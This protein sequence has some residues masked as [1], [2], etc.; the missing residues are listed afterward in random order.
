MKTIGVWRLALVY[1]G[2]FLGA[3]YFSGQELWLFF[4]HFGMGG[5]WGVLLSALLQ[6]VLCV[7]LLSLARRGEIERVEHAVIQREWRGLRTAVG[8]AEIFLLL[9]VSLVMS[10][11]VGALAAQQ[12][13]RSGTWASLVFCL[14]VLFLSRRGMSG[15]VHVFTGLVPLLIVASLTLSVVAALRFEGTWQMISRPIGEGSPLL[16]HWAI[17][18]VVFVSC[19]LFGSIAVLLPLS[20]MILNRAVAR[21]GALLGAALLLLVACAVLIAMYLEPACV[22]YELPMLALAERLHP[23]AEKLFAL[24]L[25][26]AMFGTA[27]SCTVAVREQLSRKYPICEKYSTAV[28][29]VFVALAFGGGL[30]GFGNLI[31]WVYPLFGYF[32][33]LALFGVVSHAYDL[34]RSDR[35]DGRK[36]R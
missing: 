26:A 21:R 11:G 1:A 9:G 25:L 5:V 33:I 31:G 27:L 4:G 12:T 34:H 19:N 35:G 22:V 32:G 2:C 6:G 7:V 13:G 16:P 30:L 3:G 23:L 28:M 8:F 10:A 36:K 18:A 15:L 17:S 14:G 24:L 29:G 20:R